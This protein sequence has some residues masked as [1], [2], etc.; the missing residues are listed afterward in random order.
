M[1]HSNPS[2]IEQQQY[3]YES[4]CR[5]FDEHENEVIE[6]EVLPPAIEPPD[7]ILLQDGSSLGIPKKVLAFAFLAARRAFFDNR[8][9]SL[10]DPKVL[11]TQNHIQSSLYCYQVW[12]RNFLRPC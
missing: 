5:Y 11:Y 8:D 1:A 12:L 2:A 6:I 3:A 7:G 4:L 10:T 9:T